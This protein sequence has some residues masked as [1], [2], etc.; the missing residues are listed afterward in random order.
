MRPSVLRKVVKEHISRLDET[1]EL[2]DKDGIGKFVSAAI[3][4]LDAGI[5][6]LTPWSSPCPPLSQGS[7]K[8]QGYLYT[9]R[10][11]T[12]RV[13][14]SVLLADIVLGHVASKTLINY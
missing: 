14:K 6:A 1:V 12:G 3:D 4:A 8:M 5:E 10:R 11:A 13:G 9:G 2:G 7:T